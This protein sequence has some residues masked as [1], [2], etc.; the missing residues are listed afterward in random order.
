MSDPVP[1]TCPRC[2]ATVAAEPGVLPGVRHPPRPRAA[3]RAPVERH[4]GRDRTA[5]RLAGA[6]GLPRAPRPGDRRPRRRRGDRD[7]QR[8]RGAER[9][10]DRDRRQPDRDERRLHADCARAN[11]ARDDG[12]EPD[13][14]R[15]RS[16]RRPRSRRRT[17]QR[18]SGPA[19][20]AAGRS[21]SSRSR[22]RTVS[23]RRTR[24]PPRRAAR[25][26]AAS[27]SSTPARYASLHPGYYVVF[28]G[29]FD[30]EAEAASALQRARAAFPTAY[31]REI[32]P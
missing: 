16:R 8:R 20:A 12:D 29:V 24:R 21:C 32:I 15:R 18:S 14:R 1:R 26:F 6:V 10:L 23:R 31:Q 17:R 11:R 3:R 4:V 9:H 27:A 28:T 25:V 13:R 5:E 7:L 2:N 22:R 30:S 19:A